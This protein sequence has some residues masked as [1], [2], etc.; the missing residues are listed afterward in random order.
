MTSFMPIKKTN[1]AKYSSVKPLASGKK[2]KS[3]NVAMPD[4]S[5]PTFQTLSEKLIKKKKRLLA[6][7]DTATVTLKRKKSRPQ[8]PIV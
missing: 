7:S 8:K 5:V 6:K 4:G 2:L 1:V 3:E